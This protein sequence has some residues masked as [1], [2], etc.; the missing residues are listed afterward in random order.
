MLVTFLQTSRVSEDGFSTRYCEAGKSYELGDAA[1]RDAINKGRAYEPHM[2][3]EH[4]QDILKGFEI[5]GI[6]AFAVLATEN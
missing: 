4:V 6:H 2:R 3:T 5:E 1:A